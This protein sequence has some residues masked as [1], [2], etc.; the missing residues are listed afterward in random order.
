MEQFFDI[1]RFLVPFVILGFSIIMHEVSHGFV[2][3]ALGDP[4]AK[5]AGRLTLNPIPHIDPIGS[6]LLPLLL[7]VLKAGFFIGWAKPVPVNPLNFKRRFD[8]IFVSI[9]G[10]ISNLALALVFGLFLRFFPQELQSPAM[11]AVFG[12]IVYINLLLA[13][14]NLI[15]IPP[16]DGSHVLFHFLPRSYQQ[17]QPFLMQFGIILIF[18][19]VFFRPGFLSS[20]V[21][22][23]FEPLMGLSLIQ[24]FLEFNYVF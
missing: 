20:L 10:P 4:T 19:F 11:F 24:F 23:A 2:A 8:A 13:I 5:N 14:F 1:L 18:F 17:Y 16:L 7:I 15:P 21:N 6:I 9:A 3:N 12:Y 22:F